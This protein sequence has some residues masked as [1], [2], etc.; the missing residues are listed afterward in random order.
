[1]NKIEF[2]ERL[3]ELYSQIMELE[4]QLSNE[5]YKI[6]KCIESSL[7]KEELPYDITELHL[8]RQ[9]LRDLINEYQDEI[10][11]LLDEGYEDENN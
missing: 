2:D 4:S 8:S 1:M 11:L 5:D 7:I 9:N 3:N 6:I 10:T